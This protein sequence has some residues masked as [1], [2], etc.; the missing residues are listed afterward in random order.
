MATRDIVRETMRGRE[1]GSVARTGLGETHS[2][3]KLI[4]PKYRLKL[5]VSEAR[6]LEGL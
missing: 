4:H 2:L 1:G 3:L 6:N 5:R